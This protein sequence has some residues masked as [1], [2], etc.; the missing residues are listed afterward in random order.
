MSTETVS[1]QVAEYSL[2]SLTLDGYN[3]ALSI[4]LPMSVGLIVVILLLFLL[5]K[6]AGSK[7]KGFCTEEITVKE[8]FTGT[9]V[10]IKANTEDKKVA[11]RIWTELVTRKAAIPFQRDKD[12][13]VEVY[14]SW[15][16]LFLCVR[17]Q[18]SAIP[19]EK[20]RNR[21]KVDI[22]KL[23]DI[24]TKVLNDGLRPHLTEWQ[25]KYRAW[26]TAAQCDGKY[27]ELTPQDLQ[28]QYPQYDELVS[29]IESVNL[30]L[31]AFANE[32][33]KIVR[34]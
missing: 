10:K 32:L 27:S 20:L 8:P 25:A 4:N 19:V 26:Y 7:I 12:V 30:K 1:A 17:E 11:H 18:I 28:R 6:R 15:H 21:E 16:S 31:A 34:G 33:K 13:I 22:E 9:E 14:D 29:D 5:L 3:T 23:I 24:S 2:L